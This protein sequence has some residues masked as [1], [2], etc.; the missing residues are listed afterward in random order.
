MLKFLLY[1]V[2]NEKLIK[3]LSNGQDIYDLPSLF[4]LLWKLWTYIFFSLA[5]PLNISELSHELLDRC[6]SQNVPWVFLLS[7]MF[8]LITINE[9]HFTRREN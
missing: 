4:N 2:S 9:L 6:S 3:K 1:L 7:H 5:K 8:N